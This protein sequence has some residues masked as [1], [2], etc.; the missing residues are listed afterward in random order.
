MLHNCLAREFAW[1]KLPAEQLLTANKLVQTLAQR[2]EQAMVKRSLTDDR[3]LNLQE[4][5]QQSITRVL[6]LH[7]N[8]YSSAARAL[9]IARST[10]YRKVK[11]HGI[12]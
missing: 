4:I 5:E 7:D 9:G 10:L 6:S 12:L 11:E 3:P 1:E 2:L 8:N